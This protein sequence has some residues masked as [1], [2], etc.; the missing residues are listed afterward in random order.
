MLERIFF[1]SYPFELYPQEAPAWAGAFHLLVL[2]YLG[3]DSDISDISDE[4]E[5][6]PEKTEQALSKLRELEEI[7]YPNI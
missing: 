1:I 4:Y 7:S 2:E 5:I 3:A 6:S